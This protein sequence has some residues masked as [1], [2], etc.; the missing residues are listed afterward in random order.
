MMEE[1][2]EK[3]PW[4]DAKAE[5]QGA[6]EDA[7]APEKC[8]LS[9]TQFTFYESFANA[10]RRIRSKE[11]RADAYDVIVNYALDGQ[12]PDL[13]CYSN[14]VAIVFEL[15]RPTLD[16]SRKKAASGR[17]GGQ[18]NGKQTG[19]KKENKK[20][21]EKEH[22]NEYEIELEKENDMER[23]RQNALNALQRGRSL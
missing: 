15:I 5:T 16:T 4:E 2:W 23:R 3:V 1:A 9:R 6:L 21:K 14:E 22:K 18:A 7:E 12:E 8:R 19:S 20:E 10:L 11:D 13:D 17:L